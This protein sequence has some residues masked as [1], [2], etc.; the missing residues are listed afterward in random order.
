MVVAQPFGEYRNAVAQA[1]TFPTIV[2]AL[3]V[4]LMIF[5]RFFDLPT[6]EEMF[7][8]IVRF[9]ESYGLLVV[10]IGALGEGVAVVNLYFPG[11]AAI[12]LGVVASE[13]D[14]LQASAVVVVAS[15]GFALAAQFNYLIGRCGL[16]PL[17]HRIGG[18]SLLERSRRKY[19]RQG[20]RSLFWGY[21]HP[22]IGGLLAVAAGTG[23]LRWKYFSRLTV[24]AITFWNILWGIVVFLSARPV[25]EVATSPYLVLAA[26]GIWLVGAVALSCFRVWRDRR[27][28]M[29]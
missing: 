23:R 8:L 24:G 2:L 9:F 1:A 27:R 20:A 22:N 7:N 29:N 21:F 15:C 4:G 26:L 11:S 10:F 16:Q 3:F 6:P 13:G 14:P 5:W 25:R 17:L 12:L 19:E 28:A 18:R